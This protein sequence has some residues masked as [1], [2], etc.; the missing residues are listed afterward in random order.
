LQNFLSLFFF[1]VVYDGLRAN[2]TNCQAV[3][4]IK[5]KDILLRKRIWRELDGN[6]KQNFG[7]TYAAQSAC[8][9]DALNEGIKAGKLEVYQDDRFINKMTLQEAQAIL[10]NKN[11]SRIDIKEDLILYG[12]DGKLVVRIIGIAPM[13]AVASGDSIIYQPICW[14]YYP[15]TRDFITQ[16]SVPG[17]A[18]DNRI[19]WDDFFEDRLF[20]SKVTKLSVH[21][22]E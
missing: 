2:Y 18:T 14:M 20:S 5:E 21:N 22:N 12:Q 3:E 17:L 1:G 9:I 4:P 13:K 11:I 16:Y 6:D 19:T 8:F 15:A 10:D 7:L